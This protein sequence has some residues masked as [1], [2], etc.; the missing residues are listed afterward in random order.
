MIASGYCRKS[1]LL[2]SS[3]TRR[4][5]GSCP[6]SMQDVHCS[7]AAKDI[8][9]SVSKFKESLKGWAVSIR[10]HGGMVAERIGSVDVRD[11]DGNKRTTT[12]REEIATEETLTMLMV[13]GAD[14][15]KYG[16]L[17]ADL[18]NQFVRGKGKYPK[19]MASAE[20]LLELLYETPVNQETTPTQRHPRS[21][22]TGVAARS[23][24]IPL[25]LVQ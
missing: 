23:E 4:N 6:S 10:F 14:P 21:A 24:T 5:T 22:G 15:A 2:L 19:N 12:E 7:T 20:T 16:T 8:S 3:W 17:I 18:S 13:R 25:T 1:G 11:K 9:Q